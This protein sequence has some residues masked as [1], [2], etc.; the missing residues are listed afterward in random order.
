MSNAAVSSNSHNPSSLYTATVISMY[1]E[2][3]AHHI[4]E[5]PGNTIDISIF[6]AF[7]SKD[8]RR[9][10]ENALNAFARDSARFS[11]VCHLRSK[12]RPAGELVEINVR[13]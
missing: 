10:L 13:L 2:Q 5:H 12:A 1:A 7:W 6:S 4:S 11:V 8:M 9:A 3:I